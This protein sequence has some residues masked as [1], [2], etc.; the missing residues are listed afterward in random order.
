LFATAAILFEEALTGVGNTATNPSEIPGTPYQVTVYDGFDLSSWANP[1]GSL[2]NGLPVNAVAR[3]TKVFTKDLPTRITVAGNPNVPES[4]DEYGP[5]QTYEYTD[6]P[7]DF[8]PINGTQVPI[9]ST[10]LPGEESLNSIQRQGQIHRTFDWVKMRLLVNDDRKTLNLTSRQSHTKRFSGPNSEQPAVAPTL[11]VPSVDFGLTSYI[12]DEFGRITQVQGERGDL[13]NRFTAVETRTYETGLPLI[14]ETT[15]LPLTGPDGP[16][17][18]NPDDAAAV[19]EKTYT[20]VDTHVQGGPSTVVDKIDGRTERFTYHAQLGREETHTDVLGVVT[21]TEYDAWGRKWRVTRQQKGSVGSTESKTTFDLGGRWVDESVTADGKSL[22]T[23]QEMDAFGRITKVTTYDTAGVKATEQSFGYD[24][25]GQKI[26]QS[27]VLTR[28]QAPWGNETW[29]YD[30]RGHLKEHRDARDRKLQ[31]VILPPT[32]TTIGTVEGVWTTTEDDRGIQRSEAVDLLGQKVAVVDQAGRL[33]RYFYDQD[34][35]LLQTLQGSGAEAQQRSYTYNAMGWMISRTEPEEGTTRYSKFNMF[36]TPLETEQWGRGG[37]SA[38]NRFRTTLDGHLRPTSITAVGPEG[39][40]ARVLSYLPETDPNDTRQPQGM[41]ETSTISG[42]PV[43]NLSETYVYDPIDRLTEKSVSDGIQSFSI[44]RTLDAIGNV[45]SLTYPS[46]GGKA[47]AKVITSYDKRLRPL[48]VKMDGALRGF[49]TYDQ[50]E[51][52]AITNILTLGNGATTLSRADR[53]E[54][55]LSQHAAPGG[56]V[57]ETNAM[58]WSVGGLMLTRGSDSFAYDALQR[59]QE[60]HVYGVFGEKVDQW[61]AYDS[62][63]NR[64]QSNFLYTPG[65]AGS[66]QPAELRAWRATYLNGNDLPVSLTALSAG[67]P[68]SSTAIG[69]YD[70]G[71]LYDPLGRQTRVFTTPGE[72]NSQTTW[73]YDPSGRVVMENGT[74]YLLDGEGLRFKRIRG[75]GS[76]DYT[77][78]GF[79]R[80]PLAQFSIPAPSGGTQTLLSGSTSKTSKKVSASLAAPIDPMDFAGA[81]ITQPSGPIGV[82][83]GTVVNFTGTTDAGTS[84]TWAFG[85]GGT[86]TGKTASHAFATVG[87]YT[88]TFRASA[89]GFK[90]ST[91]SVVISVLAKPSINNFTAT[92]TSITTGQS[93]T[94]AW[95]VTGGTSITIN[96]GVGI[97]TGLASKS[98]SPAATTTYTL[99]AANAA[100]SVTATATVSVSTPPPPVILSFTASPFTIALGQSSTLSW[101]V[102]NATSL[103]VSGIKVV[104]GN[105]LV[106]SPTNTTTYLLTATNAYGSSTASITLTVQTTLPVITDFFADPYSVLPGGSTT[107]RWYVSQA[108]SIKLG[109][110]PVTDDNLTVSPSNTTTY[111]LTAINLVGYATATVTVTVGAPGT[112]VWKKNIVY[113]FGQELAEDAPGVGTI[114][115]QSDYVGSPSVM[116]D[117]SG[118]VVGRSKNLP[119]GER[120]AKWGSKTIRRY[121]NHEDD[122]DSEAIYMQAR[123]YL[124]AYG[125]FSQVDPA[126]DQTKDDPESWNLYN[127][128][129]NNPITKTDPDGRKYQN[130]D[131]DAQFADKWAASDAYD[132]MLASMAK[133]QLLQH[134]Y[135]NQNTATTYTNLATGVITLVKQGENAGIYTFSPSAQ[136]NSESKNAMTLGETL[137][138]TTVIRRLDFLGSSVVAPDGGFHSGNIIDDG[139]SFYVIDV[140]KVDGK[141]EAKL[142][143]AFESMSD[144][145]AYF[146]TGNGDNPKH[147]NVFEVQSSHFTSASSAGEVASSLVSRWNAKG[148]SYVGMYPGIG[149]GNCHAFT[150]YGLNVLGVAHPAQIDRTPF[151]RMH[152]G[153]DRGDEILKRERMREAGQIF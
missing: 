70:T 125:K 68:T 119:F 116:T 23:R 88:V 114:F 58:T 5:I 43:L 31:R 27:P 14:K 39:T 60:S 112:L 95:T 73:I 71:A 47:T 129:T 141:A 144:A 66:F 136:T 40:V 33:S 26:S 105:N 25:F 61:Y 124:P 18:A 53:G 147:Y 9:W 12:Y 153:W 137:T 82:A 15:K 46:G 113:G 96:Q 81:Y 91:A 76:T 131:A 130:V 80:E 24:G 63:G 133:S 84:F 6:V 94:L 74:T 11:S 87:T 151:S 115:I 152:F 52:S 78:Y 85:D 41:T 49:M 108:D 122:P 123:E 36:G 99:T 132:S 89:S 44:T 30:D 146:G 8:P 50:V 120:M 62:F 103:S 29:T 92:P 79:G 107:L 67:I 150:H 45:T 28:T 90:P 139:T 3:R 37:G 111:T 134:M 126:Y 149:E 121:T 21:R 4:T 142:S 48:E 140:H 110:S 13:P 109:A 106:V 127:Y 101:A 104:S 38:R 16:F 69:T 77:V 83:P 72:T 100:G 54:L 20:W 93:S 86:A 98:V 22:R 2:A 138:V 19:A 35:H 143:Q 51:T 17:V 75:D 135:E 102:S 117:P 57:I 32:W 42:L 97:V 145:K 148:L 55:V 128:V 34:G 1:M 10:A 118:A 64:S 65:S 7:Q 59:L 56:A